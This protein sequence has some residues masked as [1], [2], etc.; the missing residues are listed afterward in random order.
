MTS[1]VEMLMSNFSLLPLV[2][3]ALYRTPLRT[4]LRGMSKEL[5]M[6]ISVG[7]LVE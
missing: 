4:I 5:K 1:D 7:G 6:T 3:P 2:I